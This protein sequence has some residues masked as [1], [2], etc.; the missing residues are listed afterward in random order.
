LKTKADL[1]PRL[2]FKSKKAKNDLCTV[3]Q[4][5]FYNYEKKLKILCEKFFSEKKNVFWYF[6]FEF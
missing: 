6:N 4:K 5:N 3:F 2:I 1:Y